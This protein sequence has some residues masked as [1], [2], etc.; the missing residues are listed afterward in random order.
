MEVSDDSSP[1]GCLL[2]QEGV[3]AVAASEPSKQARKHKTT[4]RNP[5]PAPAHFF[6]STAMSNSNNH[7]SIVLKSIMGWGLLV[8]VVMAASLPLLASASAENSDPNALNHTFVFV[9]GAHHR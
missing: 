2:N 1:R 8:V 9:V 3:L 5:Q 6:F 4:T 7:H